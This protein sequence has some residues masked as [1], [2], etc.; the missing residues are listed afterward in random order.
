MDVIIRLILFS[1]GLIV[2]IVWISNNR[3]LWRNRLQFLK[4]PQTLVAI[5]FEA[6][7]IYQLFGPSILPFPAGVFTGIIFIPAD[8][9]PLSP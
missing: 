4:Q 8:C 2:S 6:F 5:A 7:V 9:T 1:T 3:Y